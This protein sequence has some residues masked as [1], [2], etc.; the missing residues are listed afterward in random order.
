MDFSKRRS[1]KASISIPPTQ[2]P[3]PTASLNKL[4]AQ[5]RKPNLG[6][7]AAEATRQEQPRAATSKRLRAAAAVR[8][9]GGQQAASKEEQAA[10]DPSRSSS[11]E[12]KQR[13]KVG[14]T[15][16]SLCARFGSARLS[17]Q[18]NERRAAENA[19][20]TAQSRAER[21]SDFKVEE[22]RVPPAGLCRR[23]QLRV[24]PER[25]KFQK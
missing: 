20:S 10:S 1:S 11:P 9:G 3:L 13:Q 23:P 17:L 19:V 15:S 24:S 14:P 12:E 2:I 7:G 25:K 18:E 4:A 22:I 8:A 21:P 5:L 6:G 16:S